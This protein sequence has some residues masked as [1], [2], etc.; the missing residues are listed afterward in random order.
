[1][2]RPPAIRVRVIQHRE[3]RGVNGSVQ[4]LPFHFRDEAFHGLRGQSPQGD[5]RGLEA[6]E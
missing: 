6:R 3:F 1:M 5:D 4:N 2:S